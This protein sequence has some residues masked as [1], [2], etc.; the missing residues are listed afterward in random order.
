MTYWISIYCSNLKMAIAQMLAYRFAILIWAVWGFV[1]PLISLAVWTAVTSSNKSGVTG[2]SGQQ[3]SQADF[4][5]YYL[6]FMIFGHLTMSWDAFEFA[7]RIQDGRLS[8]KL[9]KPL[10][11]I[12]SDIAFNIAF[13]L[14]TSVMI[15]PAWILLFILLHPTP[16]A[17]LSGLLLAVPALMLAGALRYMLQYALATIAFWT[18]RVEAINQLFFTVDSFLSGRIAPLSLLPG[19][20]G[21]IALYSPFRGMGAFPVELALGRIPTSEI[22]PGF[23]LQI[24]WLSIALMLFRMLWASGIRQYSAVGA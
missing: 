20:L 11:P 21:S 15:L 13:K 18:T 12:H 1:G 4:A 5:A 2:G 10:H 24:I 23:A 16:P 17:S 3:F 14:C 7:S 22:L 19:V 6:L 9:L 8:P